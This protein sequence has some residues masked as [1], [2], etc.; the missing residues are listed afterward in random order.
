MGAV[1][2][3][4]FVVASGAGS[5][6]ELTLE[7]RVQRQ[8]DIQAILE[9]IHEYGRLLDARDFAGYAALFAKEGE[10]VGGFGRLKGPAMIRAVVEEKMSPRDGAPAPGGVHVFSN[11]RI[12]VEGD[13]ATAVTK[14][15]DVVP[16][17][18]GRPI[19][20]ML[21][22]YDDVLVREDGRWKFLR[23]VAHGDIPFHDPLADAPQ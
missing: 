23:R 20:L 19:T 8:E 12:R 6:G 17:S 21:G 4:A 10:W 7:Q 22:H 9:L 14:W 16:G 1:V 5:A 11:E 2:A 13:R 15:Q 3:A 18:D